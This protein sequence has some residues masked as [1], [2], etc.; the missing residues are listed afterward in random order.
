MTIEIYNGIQ[1]KIIIMHNQATEIIKKNWCVT[2]S[3]Y[4]NK[5][6]KNFSM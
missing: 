3:N 1:L 4:I 5:K 2:Y 6:K